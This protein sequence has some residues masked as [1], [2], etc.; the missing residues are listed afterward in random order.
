MADN[1]DMTIEDRPTALEKS[2]GKQ[3]AMV[4]ELRSAFS[5]IV[6]LEA[7]QSQLFARGLAEGESG[8]DEDAG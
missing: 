2:A 6:N 5:A 3:D 8:R 4:R 7:R 1:G